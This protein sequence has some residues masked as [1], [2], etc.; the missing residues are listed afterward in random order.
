MLRFSTH[1]QFG[2]VLFSFMVA[3]KIEF[4]QKAD[5]KAYLWS[6]DANG[7]EINDANKERE[8]SITILKMM[9]LLILIKSSIIENILIIFNFN[10]HGKRIYSC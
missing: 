7:C 5:D 6:S 9:S 10:F 2:V 1:G 4:K 3:S 8:Q